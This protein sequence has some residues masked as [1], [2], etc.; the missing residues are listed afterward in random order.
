L[1]LSNL[2]ISRDQS[3]Q[4]QKLAAVPEEI[5]EQALREPN[6]STSGIIMRHEVAER[7]PAA[8]FD[9]QAALFVWGRLLD[10]ERGEGVCHEAIMRSAAAGSALTSRATGRQACS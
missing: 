2:N 10:F 1:K 6:A 7:S 4:W 9:N 3:S 5:F 8:V